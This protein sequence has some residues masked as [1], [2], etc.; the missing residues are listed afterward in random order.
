MTQ[1]YVYVLTNE[2]MPGLVKI[3]YTSDIRKRIRELSGVSGVPTPFICF[4]AALVADCELVEKKL[5]DGLAEVRPYP[6]KEFFRIAP[7]RVKSL[8]ELTVHEPY[9]FEDDSVAMPSAS[10]ALPRL[11]L[12]AAG[13]KEGD[14][15]HF[16]RDEQIQVIAKKSNL[17]EMDG[18]EVTLA[19]ATQLALSSIGQ[20]WQ[21]GAASEYWKLGDDI[22][23]E[24][25]R[26]HD[27][28]RAGRGFSLEEVF[29]LIAAIIT[30]LNQETGDFAK[31]GEI[32]RRLANDSRAQ[33]L[34]EAAEMLTRF[35]SREEISSNMVA[36]WS[37]QITVDQNEFARHFLR[38]KGTKGYEYWDQQL[39]TTPN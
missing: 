39:G 6:R 2:A 26:K 8:I 25:I 34:L 13:L 24:L 21:A 27:G 1:G 28:R 32:A 23:S 35:S 7:E 16:V 20:K 3:G 29:P 5:H 37:Q 38:K 10:A 22:L 17:V 4:F 18:Q 14:L 19:K 12:S 11:K 33:P 15:L 30:A 31:H 9:L 36:W